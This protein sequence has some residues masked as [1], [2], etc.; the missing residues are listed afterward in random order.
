MAR[1]RFN[2]P[3]LTNLIDDSI[4]NNKHNVICV[5]GELGK[6]KTTLALQLLYSIYKDWD[7]V[8]KH[9]LFTFWEI[10]DALKKLV[11]ERER[12]PMLV[13]DDLAVY[14]HRSLIQYMHPDVR[15]FFSKYNFIRTYLAN[16]ILTTPSIDFVPRQLLAFMTCDVWAT[17]R[18]KAD[19]DRAL[20]VRNFRGKTK[21]RTKNY[22]GYDVTWTKLPKDVYREYED[23]RHDHALEAFMNPNAIFVSS[24]LTPNRQADTPP[25]P[26][27]SMDLKE[28][29]SGRNG[30]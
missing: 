28:R 8:L 30:D 6:G 9:C 17:R 23:M 12:S 24:M 2:I 26:H 29:R 22:D 18:G 1:L 14:F 10:K 4:Y 21:T 19:F 11:I 25:P 5:W 13:W 20:V 15:D 3:R 7:V 27:T 16:M